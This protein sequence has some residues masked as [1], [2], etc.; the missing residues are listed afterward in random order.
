M[1]DGPVTDKLVD[2]TLGSRLRSFYRKL[3]GAE[4]SSH[5]TPAVANEAASQ[6]LPAR[7]GRYA[8]ARKLGEGG[9][10]VVYAARD[11]LLERTVAV[12][13]MSSL[14]NDETARKRFWREAR[15]AASVNHP[16]VCQ[17]FEIGED[18]GVL[19]IAMELLE[20]ESLAERLGR[21]PLSLSQAVPIALG[22]LGALSALHARGIVHRDLKPS[23]VF[24]TPHGVKLLDFGLARPE[25]ERSLSMTATG[26]TRTGIAMGTPRYMSPEQVTADAVD[27]RSDVFAAGAILFEMLAG[28]P[29]FG[30]RNVVEI[31]HATLHEHPP[32]LT[33]SPAVAAVDRVIRRALAKRPADRPASAEAMAAELRAVRGSDADD[34]PVLAH[35]LTRLVVLPFRVLRPDAE[36][37]FLAFSLPDAIATSLSGIGSLVV[38]SS[39]AAARFGGDAPDLKA[40]AAEAD[41]DRVVMG[42]LLRS[43]DQLRASAQLVEAPGGTLLTSHTVQSSLGDLFGLQ[44]DIARRVVQ[45][46]S[47]PLGGAVPSPTPDAPHNARAYE[48]YLRANELART[49][50]GLAGARDLYQRCLEL[51]P[52]FAPA[53][54]R[55]GRCYRV[56]GKYVE[57]TPDSEERAEEAIRRALEL[58]PRLSV[59][60]KFYANLEADVGQAQRALVRLLGEA[61][62]HGN[63]PELFAGLVHAC[64]Y[65]GLYDQSIAAHAE[66]RR[67][68]PN[69]PTSLEQ[70]LLMTGDIQRLL[71]VEPPLVIAGADDG[72]RVI[73]LGL[74]G[75]R[76][77][78]R[79]ALRAMH[80]VPRVAAFRMWTDHLL[81]WLDRRQADMIAGM[82]ALVGLKVM[83]DPEATFQEGWLLCDVGEHQRGLGH[84]QRAVAKGYYVA[85]TLAASPQFDALRADP[86]FKALVAE[87]EAG[88]E[89]SLAAFREGGGE[90]LLGG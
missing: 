16:N 14:A 23:N 58:N 62:R 87:A 48:L 38:R 29:A 60:H 15:A 74:A 66:A 26:L 54:A 56:I 47:L 1:I 42:T 73:G 70:T 72:I 20:G 18:G 39:A 3:T 78:A 17:I 36:T 32:A 9:M 59:A 45:A 86:A 22:V 35:A 10:G 27:A 65:C 43:G 41:V 7:I 57:V 25:L 12:K 8:I 61:N 19:F 28:R 89:R 75:R 55:L 34:T 24:L 76:D 90:R 82:P 4:S 84:L 46:L 6:V 83:D 85:A 44:D 31:L 33:G 67:L 64:R 21:G 71:S 50:D 2:H 63:D 53:W 79:R 68:D 49:Y 51:D 80:Q 69:V 30:G 52:E 5:P 11:E 40:L 77:E 13:T 81:A 37:D 88:R